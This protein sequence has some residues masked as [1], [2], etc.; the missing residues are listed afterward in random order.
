[1]TISFKDAGYMV[2]GGEL[3]MRVGGEGRAVLHL[4]S[5]AGIRLS[6]VIDTLAHHHR[7]LSPIMPGFDGQPALPGVDSVVALADMLAG[8]I[9]AHAGGACD[10]IGESFGG[11]IALWL[12]VRHPDLVQQLVLEAPAGLR[13]DGKGG[14]GDSEDDRVRRLY[15][16]PRKAPPETRTEA[17][18]MANRRTVLGYT[19][20]AAF[21]EALAERL[22]D[23]RARTL[24]VMG[25]KD[26]VIPPET[27]HLLKVRIPSSHLIYVHGAAHALEIDQPERVARL[28]LDFLARGESFLV[29]GALS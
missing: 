1:M 11:W 26:G 14:L 21:D 8:F 23:I 13:P 12:A 4:H 27:G 25:T 28:V 18:R 29:R 15:A 10:V 24:I 3:R 19:K 6:G 17:Q 5:A 16:D 7:V 9:R 20:V 2:D 22:G